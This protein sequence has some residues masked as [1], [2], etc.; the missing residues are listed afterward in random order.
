MIIKSYDISFCDN[1]AML[2]FSK[3]AQILS[4]GV[5]KQ[6]EAGRFLEI[7][8]VVVKEEEGDAVEEIYFKM[9]PVTT[10]F[11]VKAWQYYL[12]TI[13]LN[14]GTSTYIVIAE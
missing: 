2:M 12:G 8:F 3:G 13:A 14:N 7:P 4:I 1:K 9:V 6:L 5:R 11:E 10:P